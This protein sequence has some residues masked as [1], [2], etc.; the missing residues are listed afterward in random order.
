INR[1]IIDKGA[2]KQLNII[3]NL[4][5]REDVNSIILATDYD[6][7]GQV[8]GDEILLYLNK[9]K[10]VYRILLNEWTA[11]EIEKGMKNLKKNEEMKPLQDAGIGRQWADWII[12]IN[13]T[14]VAT[15][16]YN[17]NKKN[18]LNVG[19][20]LLPTLKIIYDRDKEIENFKSSKYYKLVSKFKT[21]NNFEFESI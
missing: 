5:E 7:E 9:N 11:E 4:I 14:S 21:K 12:G 19:R 2:E 6:R 18:I 10:P 20:V 13:L 17:P 3:K 15:L 16:R 1:N 8:I